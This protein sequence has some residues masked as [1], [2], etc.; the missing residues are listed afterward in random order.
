MDPT[1]PASSTGEEGEELLT[2]KE[3]AEEFGISRQA[4]HRLRS[5]GVF[6]S[7]V[8]TGGSTRLRFERS[9]VEAYFAAHPKRP[10]RRTDLTREAP[11][12]EE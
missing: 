6:P 1:R 2:I 10:G 12:A 8:M 9:A 7:P 3:I 5:R 11:P 4:L